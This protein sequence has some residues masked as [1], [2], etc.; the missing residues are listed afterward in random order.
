MTPLHMVAI[1]DR[2]TATL[3]RMPMAWHPLQ[4]PRPMHQVLL[5]LEWL[6]V[7]RTIQ[8]ATQVAQA[9]VLHMRLMG[10]T[11]HMK[12]QAMILHMHPMT[13]IPRT[14]PQ[15]MIPLKALTADFPKQT[16]LHRAIA[17]LLVTSSLL[18][19]RN[20]GLLEEADQRAKP[21]MIRTMSA[22]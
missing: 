11:L 21:S 19:G 3:L 22:W 12:P 6:Q 13:M 18:G 17:A 8:V 10:M 2:I 4:V 14:H 15:G 9:M 5:L 7:A 1:P 16:I 20:G